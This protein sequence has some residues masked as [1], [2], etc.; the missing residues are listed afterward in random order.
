MKT[1]AALF[2]LLAIAFLVL[3]AGTEETVNTPASC[4]M[5]LQDAIQLA[6]KHNHDIH[7][8]S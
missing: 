1:N 5:T 4:H 2:L 6:A 7:I 3:P 8:A